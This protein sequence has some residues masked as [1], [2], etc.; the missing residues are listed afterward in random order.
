MRS[1]LQNNGRHSEG[2]ATTMSLYLVVF[3]ILRYPI[4]R[5]QNIILENDMCLAKLDGS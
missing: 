4:K 3:I 5:K 1:K 2:F